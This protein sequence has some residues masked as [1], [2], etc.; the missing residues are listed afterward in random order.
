MSNFGANF[1]HYKTKEPIN[2]TLSFPPMLMTGKRINGY[3]ITS[4]KQAKTQGIDVYLKDAKPQKI[5]PI[6]LMKINVYWGKRKLSPS[7]FPIP[8]DHIQEKYCFPST[9]GVFSVKSLK[10]NLVDNTITIRLEYVPPY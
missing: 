7:I 10:L 8:V 4:I 5:H 2:I 6:R 3:E 1:F 9:L